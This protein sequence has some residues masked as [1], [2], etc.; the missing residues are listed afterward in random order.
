MAPIHADDVTSYQNAQ[1]AAASPCQAPAPAPKDYGN[2]NPDAPYNPPGARNTDS[3]LKLNPTGEVVHNYATNGPAPGDLVFRWI[4]GSVCAAKNTDPRIQVVAYNEDTYVL[5]ENPCVNWEAPFTYLLLGNRGALLIDT[6]ATPEADFYP[7]RVTVDQILARWCRVRRKSSVPLRVVLTS[8]EDVAQ[9][10][11]IGQF[12][13]RAQTHV[14]PLEFSARM[15]FHGLGSNWRQG[16]GRID[17]GDRV[18]EVIPTPGTHKDGLS[19]YDSYTCHLFTGDLLYPGRVQIANDR[20]YVASLERLQQWKQSHPVKWVMGG[21]VEMMFIPGR[22]YPRF[23]TNRPFEH[24]LQLEAV[25]ID[26][27]LEHARGAVGTPGVVFRTDFILLNRVSPDEKV[28]QSAPNL[29]FVPVPY[30]ISL[31]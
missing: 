17:L 14:T 31:Q 27:A 28:Y 6:G 26:E 1:A 18:V 10:Q 20:D 25:A 23:S 24:V 9:N 19:F 30:W 12:A 4:H 22:A 8:G 15:E 2:G 11:G 29:P 7:L 3:C 16:L 21:H 5:R 13:D